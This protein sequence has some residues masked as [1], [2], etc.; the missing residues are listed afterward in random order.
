MQHLEHVYPQVISIQ[1]Y[2]V[3][4]E[5]EFFYGAGYD[6]KSEFKT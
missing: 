3:G 4:S 2:G 5:F 1:S 6:L